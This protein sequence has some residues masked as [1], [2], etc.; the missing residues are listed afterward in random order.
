LSDKQKLLNEPVT[1]Y[2]V[3][4]LGMKSFCIYS[5]PEARVAFLLISMFRKTSE[6]SRE[7]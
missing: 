6:V 5:A 3:S 1:G 4:N 7:G 2:P